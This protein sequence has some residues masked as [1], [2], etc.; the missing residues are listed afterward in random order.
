MIATDPE[1]SNKI[2]L[3]NQTFG[4]TPFHLRGKV[5]K[6]FRRRVYQL[7]LVLDVPLLR[8]RRHGMRHFKN[9]T[10]KHSVGGK[11]KWFWLHV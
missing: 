7:Q 10:E 8:L 5:H 11:R 9:Y 6:P 3:G 4:K 1:D 2:K